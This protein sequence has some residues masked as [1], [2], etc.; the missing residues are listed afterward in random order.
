[1]PR[2]IRTRA[3]RKNVFSAHL[4]LGLVKALGGGPDS[5]VLHPRKR[6]YAG[7]ANS[8]RGYDENQLGP[9]VL[10]IDGPTL[11]SGATSAGG[12]TC[13]LTAQAIQFC[14]PNSA[15]LSNSDFI[16]QPLGGTT[17]VEGSV[18][19]RVPLPLGLTF[20]N[21][22]GA[23]FLDAGLLTQPDIRGI[24]TIAG[25]MKGTGAITPGFGVRYSRPW[26]RSASTSASIR[27]GRRVSRS[28]HRCWRTGRSSSFP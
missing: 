14:D 20:R 21:F 6:F 28:S 17:L 27:T 25:I 7:G 9:R 12:G 22:V 15:E 11:V 19:Y 10:T 24:Q 23:V 26:G 18:E 2:C 8:V 4:R 13:A 1:M 3:A 16:A 5:G